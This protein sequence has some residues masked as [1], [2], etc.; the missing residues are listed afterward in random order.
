MLEERVRRETKEKSL[1]MVS[2]EGPWALTCSIPLRLA[3]NE[4]TVEPPNK[5][6]DLRGEQISALHPNWTEKC[7]LHR[8]FYH[9]VAVVQ[10]R[11]LQM[12][13]KQGR[14]KISPVVLSLI[15]KV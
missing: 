10:Q 7:Q 4:E 9:S 14:P 8:T 6:E 3:I 13:L 5:N 1:V 15:R 12:V 2:E 11:W